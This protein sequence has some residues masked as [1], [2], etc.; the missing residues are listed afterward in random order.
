VVTANLP[1]HIDVMF[2]HTLSLLHSIS[3]VANCI[4]G[5]ADA[6]LLEITALALMQYFACGQDTRG[7]RGDSPSSEVLQITISS[8]G[9][10]NVLTYH[11][12]GECVAWASLCS[13]ATD[14]T[15]ACGEP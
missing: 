14:S 8:T 3:D 9:R 2:I 6:K 10:A 4:S 13:A 15:A 11:T 12:L 7:V 1:L 5:S